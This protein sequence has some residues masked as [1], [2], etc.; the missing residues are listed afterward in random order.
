MLTVNLIIFSTDRAIEKITGI[1]LD[2]WLCC[3]DL[4][5]PAGFRIF[6]SCSKAQVVS[7]FQQ[8]KVVIITTF[9]L[10]NPGADGTGC[11]EI[12]RPAGHTTKFPGWDQFFIN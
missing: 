12:H 10:I 3:Q 7:L 5:D 11:G 1:K 9:D 2:T 8:Y 4:Y 6:Y